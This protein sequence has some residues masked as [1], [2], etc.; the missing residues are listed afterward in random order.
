[1]PNF[2]LEELGAKIVKEQSSASYLSEQAGLKLWGF[3]LIP[4]KPPCVSP[5]VVIQGRAPMVPGVCWSFAG[6]QGHLTIKL[7]HSI[8]ISHVT[9]GHI[10]KMMSPS[11]KVS[12]APRTFSV[13]VSHRF[14][15]HHCS[16]VAFYICVYR[17]QLYLYLFLS[18]QGKR[19]L[20]DSG[21]H[22]GTFVYDE[23]GDPLQTFRIP[24]DKVDVIRSITLHVLNNWGNREYSCL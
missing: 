21:V 5:R 15:L 24:D 22:L 23:N 9:L 10:S 6:S 17:E 13:F 19:A 7:P 11:G 3:T 20:D 12:S 16:T 2:A 1:M 14:P 4:A 18:F 8:A